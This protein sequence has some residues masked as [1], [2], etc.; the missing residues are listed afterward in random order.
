MGEMSVKPF[1]RNLWKS[2]ITL[3]LREELMYNVVGLTLP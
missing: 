3:Q 2:A 1:G